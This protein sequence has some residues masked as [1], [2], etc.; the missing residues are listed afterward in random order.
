MEQTRWTL[1]ELKH[2]NEKAMVAHTNPHDQN[3][4]ENRTNKGDINGTTS[5]FFEN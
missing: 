3:F 4:K 2:K 1:M 5:L